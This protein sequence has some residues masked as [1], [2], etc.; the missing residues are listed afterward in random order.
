MHRYFF[1]AI[2][3]AI[4]IFNTQAQYITAKI[5]ELKRTNSLSAQRIEQF[6]NELDSHIEERRKE[7]ISQIHERFKN[8]TI[9]EVLQ[10]DVKEKIL[11]EKDENGQT[12]LMFCAEYGLLSLVEWCIQNKADITIQDNTG[13]TALMKAQLAGRSEIVASLQEHLKNEEL[14]AL[15]LDTSTSYEMDG[16]DGIEILSTRNSSSNSP[17][18]KSPLADDIRASEENFSEK[19]DK[20]LDI[21]K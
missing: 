11:N 16:F 5:R 1:I 13:R 19:N 3:F 2:A 9:R 15:S 12:L 10:N 8:V 6:K 14:E 4:T 17:Q 21:P 18:L 20:Q 7:A